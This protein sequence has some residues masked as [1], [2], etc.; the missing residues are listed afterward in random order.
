MTNGEKFQS[1]LTWT[2]SSKD[3]ETAGIIVLQMFKSLAKI[4]KLFFIFKDTD[5]MARNQNYN[6]W[7]KIH[8]ERD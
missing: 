4:G 2:K 8:I 6:G 5:Q 3:I 7:H 1:K